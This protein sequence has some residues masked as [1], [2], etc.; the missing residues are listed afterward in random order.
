[1][2]TI[3][4]SQVPP[5]ILEAL[6]AGSVK[7]N[8]EAYIR[9]MQRYIAE[10]KLLQPGRREDM[11]RAAFIGAETKASFEIVWEQIQR[12]TAT[13]GSPPLSA[14][15]FRKLMAITEK[16]EPATMD[17]LKRIT[18]NV[19]G[20]GADRLLA[21]ADRQDTLDGGVLAA[22]FIRA[23]QEADRLRNRHPD[24]RGPMGRLMGKAALQAELLLDEVLNGGRSASDGSPKS[25]PLD[26]VRYS[27]EFARGS[28][29]AAIKVI[30]RLGLRYVGGGMRVR[31][32][33]DDEPLM[34]SM[35]IPVSGA[36]T[37]ARA[38]R[39]LSMD[40]AVLRTPI[41]EDIHI[42]FRSAS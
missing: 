10:L 19:F 1:M 17:A 39:E 29:G 6:T 5:G 15:E 18:P 33:Y 2:Q 16:L 24:L 37:A 3:E 42:G 27:L 9:L 41:P 4:R 32:V 40:L 36:S 12:E 28:L 26:D 11:L 20:P 35:K 34:I 22:A 31:V 30:G 7:E 23:A 25:K 13:A 21:F 8:A 14:A 38:N